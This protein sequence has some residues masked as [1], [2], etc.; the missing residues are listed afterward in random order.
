M[1]DQ[2]LRDG[3]TAGPSV[4]SA[5]NVPAGSLLAGSKRM[6][7]GSISALAFWSAIAL[8]VLYLPLLAKGLSSVDDLLAFLALLGVHILALL[9]GRSHR[10]H[11]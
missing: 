3:N 2:S 7:V 9:A 6:V 8:P 11:D 1:T 4:E 5:S 10:R